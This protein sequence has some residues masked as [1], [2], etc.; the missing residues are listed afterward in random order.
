MDKMEEIIENIVKMEWAFFDKVKN[1]G[2][3]ASCQDDWKTFSAMRRSQYMAWNAPMLESWQSDLI[4]AREEGRNPLTEKYGYMMFISAPE[5]SRDVAAQLPA[6]SDEKKRLARSITDKLLP[7]NRAFRLRYPHVAGHGRPLTT[8]EEPKAGYTSIE[9][10]E[11]GELY[12]Y[13]QKT[14]ELFSEHLTELEKSGVSYPE[15]VVGN[16][17]KLRGFKSL[18]QAEEFIAE[19]DKTYAN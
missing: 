12:T 5:E 8:S 2:G 16:G 10:Y 4:R 11:L 17:M 18:A 6:V 15:A 1:E 19:R 7:L 13:S 14:L 9:T 3:R